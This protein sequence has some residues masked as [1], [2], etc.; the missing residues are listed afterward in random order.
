MHI[1]VSAWLGD[2]ATARRGLVALD[3]QYPAA[4]TESRLVLL[5]LAAGHAT[6]GGAERERGLA[7]LDR[8]PRL[9][10]DVLAAPFWDRVPGA[11]RPSPN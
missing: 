2:S 11:A 5:C 4:T 10:R 1:V 7:L 6:L 8:I 9:R 3:R